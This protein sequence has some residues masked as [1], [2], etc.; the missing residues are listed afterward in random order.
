MVELHGILNSFETRFDSENSIRKE[1]AFR[2]FKKQVDLESK[3]GSNMEEN[4]VI[5]L[6]MGYSKYKGKLHFELFIC[7]ELGH[8][9]AKCP[10]KDFSNF[11]QK[12]GKKSF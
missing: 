4:F 2:A 5:K 7:G 6:Q 8:F 1:A 12:H 3:V 9:M 11:E 10:Y